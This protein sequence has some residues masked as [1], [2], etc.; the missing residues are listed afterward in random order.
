MHHFLVQPW[1]ASPGHPAQSLARTYRAINPYVNPK[2]IIYVPINC[3]LSSELQLT[4]DLCSAVSVKGN[5]WMQEKIGSLAS[6]TYFTVKYLFQ[7]I[8]RT[9]NT[10]DCIF[11]LDANLYILS[12]SLRI[13][14]IQAKSIDALCMVGP[15]FYQRSL[16]DKLTKWLL[17]KKLFQFNS[18]RLHLRTLE[19]VESWHQAL[20]KFKSRISY[21]PSLEL[22]GSQRLG[23]NVITTRLSTNTEKNFLIAGQIRPQK[24]S[25]KI[26]HAFFQSPSLGRL[27]VVGRIIDPHLRNL[28]N[29]YA[30]SNIQIQDQFLAEAVMGQALIESDYNL[31]LY[32]NWDD[33]MEASM[34][35]ESVKYRCPVVA[36]EGGWLGNKVASEQLGWLLP[37]YSQESLDIL[38]GQLPPPGSEEYQKVTLHLEECYVRWSSSTVIND[39]LSCLN[40]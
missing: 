18:F 28:L 1:F 22:Q 31:M 25:E 9:S 26:A 19:L 21:L 11:F 10:D 12:L 16:M 23:P 34:L 13:Y 15:E 4:Q 29:Q 39:F 20:P 5:A 6:G 33:R 17:V 37:R 24:S 35:F 8:S 30:C 38:L 27:R 14:R 3:Q 36:Y 40:W 7:E 2:V 32:V